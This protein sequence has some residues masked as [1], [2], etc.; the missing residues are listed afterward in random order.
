MNIR[1]TIAVFQKQM[2]DTL[3]NKAVLIQ[4]VMFPFLAVIMKNSIKIEGM[5]ENYFVTLF[6]SMYLAMAPIT[7]MASIIAEE[8][9][10]N[11]L[12]VLIMSNVRPVEYL[13]GVGTYVWLFCMAGSGV[14]ALTGNYSGKSV[15]E[16]MGIMAVGITISVLIG[17]AIGTWSRN[18]M[19]A[20]SLTVPVMMIFSFVPMLSSYNHTIARVGK[21]AYSQQIYTLMN[22]I[23]NLQFK[24][25]SV[26]VILVNFVVMFSLFLFAYQKTILKGQ[27]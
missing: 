21:V 24:G 22:Q 2:E 11:T 12:R 14:L 25:E 23:G 18:Q 9:E 27:Y 10:K 8:K 13:I 5:P 6:A 4:F 15:L 1:K 20:T 26:A 19:M 7:S 3:K 16:F 17:A